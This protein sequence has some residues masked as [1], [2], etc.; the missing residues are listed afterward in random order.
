VKFD[1]TT[2]TG[3]TRT[4]SIPLASLNG[5]A[6]DGTAA[7]VA[8]RKAAGRNRRSPEAGEL[9]DASGRTPADCKDASGA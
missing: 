8:A 4:Q 1:L 2:M 3:I 9:Q 6:A 5:M 7:L